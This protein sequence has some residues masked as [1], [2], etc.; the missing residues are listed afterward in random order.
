M[1]DRT[2]ALLPP[3]APTLTPAEADAVS[4]AALLDML[5]ETGYS[6]RASSGWL[7]LSQGYDVQAIGVNIPDLLEQ[8][9]RIR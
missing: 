6:L 5:E 8:V 3:P 9:R 7:V 4:L 1:S 2:H